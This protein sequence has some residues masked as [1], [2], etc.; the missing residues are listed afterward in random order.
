MQA[1]NP[2]GFL[3]HPHASEAVNPGVEWLFIAFLARARCDLQSCC[4]RCVRHTC[5]RASWH[6]LMHVGACAC[7]GGCEACC[8]WPHTQLVA[9][10]LPCE[11]LYIAITCCWSWGIHP[12]ARMRPK[13][14]A[15]VHSMWPPGHRNLSRIIRHPAL[16][17][18]HQSDMISPGQMRH[19]LL[20][21]LH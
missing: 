18:V 3:Q 8:V 12:V 17:P 21:D 7:L 13:S 19:S 9:C 2:V 5:A 4:T 16:L 6:H 10:N 15:Q 11:E 20:K 1:V 14:Q